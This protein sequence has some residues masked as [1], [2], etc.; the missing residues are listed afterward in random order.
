MEV[1]K[2]EIMANQIVINRDEYED[3]LKYKALYENEKS[4]S[5]T[6]EAIIN[7]I[8]GN[9]LDNIDDKWTPEQKEDVALAIDSISDIFVHF[10]GLE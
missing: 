9:R 2:G 4:H 7:K 8:I 1:V 10:M 3:L 6:L 5:E